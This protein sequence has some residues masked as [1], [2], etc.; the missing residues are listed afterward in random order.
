MQQRTVWV[1]GECW[2][3]DAIG[4][5]VMWLGPVTTDLGHG[6]FHAC[7]PCIRRLEERVLAYQQWRDV[8]A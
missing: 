2:R 7:A 4:V 5:P 8:S 6:P 1:I 3:C